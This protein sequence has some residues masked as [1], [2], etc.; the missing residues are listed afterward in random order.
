[1]SDLSLN[2]DPT[3]IGQKGYG[4]LLLHQGDLTLTADVNPAGTDSV[5]QFVTQRLKLYLGEWFMNTSDGLPWYQQILVANADK[6]VV[7]GL[8]RDCILG[9]PGVTTLLSYT[10]HQDLGKR[11]M[12]VSFSILTATGAHISA[13]VPMTTGGAS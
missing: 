3:L 9:T 10:S 7:D 6:S 8:L 4:D 12:T 13:Q 1:M 2:Y 5:I 11:T